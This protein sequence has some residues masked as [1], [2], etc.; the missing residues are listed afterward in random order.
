[1]CFYR[2]SRI[3]KLIFGKNVKTIGSSAFYNCDNLSSLEFTK[4]LKRIDSHAFYDCDGFNWFYIPES[5][6][7]IGEDAIGY[8]VTCDE[9]EEVVFSDFKIYAKKG[10]AAEKY[11]KKNGLKFIKHVTHKKAESPT[12][13]KPTVR[14]NGYKYFECSICHTEL[15]TE[16]TSLLKCSVPTVKSVKKSKGGVKITW[17]KVEGG[18]V[19]RVYRKVKSGGWK[20]ID[21]TKSSYFTDKTAKSGKTYYYTVRAKNEAGLSDYNRKGVSIKYS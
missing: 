20:Y 6:T 10:S 4:G 8:Y 19:Y 16:I 11:A 3:T 21:S 14:S 2:C 9:G 17:D 13:K 1:M 5:V 7:H 15:E 12:V 18:D